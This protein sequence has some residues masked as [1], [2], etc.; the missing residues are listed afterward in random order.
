MLATEPSSEPE[1]APEADLALLVDA[2]R[3]AGEIALG[4]WRN[5]QRV[6][7]KD[8]D[9][10]PVGEAD[11]A[12]DR[13]LTEHLRGARPDYGWMSEETADLAEDRAARNLFIVDPIDGTRAFLKGEDT[14]SHSLAVV[15]DRVP[16]AAVVYLPA[17]DL[18]YTAAGGVGA[19]SN[20]ALLRAEPGS[21]G[22]DTANLLITKPNLAPH[23]WRGPV[24]TLTRHFRPSLAYRMALAAEGR[25]DGMVTLRD[26][27]EWDVAAGALIA[28]EAGLCVT[29]RDGAALRFNSPARKT[30][31]I[32][33]ATPS[34]HAELRARLA[35]GA[36]TE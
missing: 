11:L 28:M 21:G 29:D 27:W 4:Y 24:P 1:G 23:L 32:L 12:A 31:G 18:L 35:P 6:W 22:L 33:A 26:A 17:K 2:A 13:V 30:A 25:F 19:W 34:L 16:V 9:Q 10:G 7:E 8:E 14:W 15:R 3:A 36:W 20:G 5:A